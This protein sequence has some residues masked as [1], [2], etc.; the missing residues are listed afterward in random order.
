MDQP[1]NLKMAQDRIK[2]ELE[3]LQK[4]KKKLEEKITEYKKILKFS[5]LFSKRN[6]SGEV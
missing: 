2:R 6:F 1:K 4:K 5:L 3:D